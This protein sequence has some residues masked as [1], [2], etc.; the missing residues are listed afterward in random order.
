M[1]DAMLARGEVTNAWWLGDDS[2]PTNHV[3]PNHLR[4][5]FQHPHLSATDLQRVTLEMTRDLNRTDSEA[6]ARILEVG[7]RRGDAAFAMTALAV[8]ARFESDA[9]DLLERM[10]A[11]MAAT[12]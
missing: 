11:T 10:D 2:L 12:V 7:R 5:Y 6:V 1:Y 3:L 9:R 8:R 4:V